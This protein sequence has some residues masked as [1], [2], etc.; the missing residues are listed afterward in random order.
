MSGTKDLI[1]DYLHSVV[2]QIGY[3]RGGVFPE[4]TLQSKIDFFADTKQSFGSTALVLSGG[5]TFGLCHLGVVKALS[6]NGLLPRV[7]SGS[8]VGALIA[9]LVC[10]HADNEIHVCPLLY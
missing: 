10:I 7:I 1:H 9:A 5:A 2:D 6:Q 8:S 3:I 4:L